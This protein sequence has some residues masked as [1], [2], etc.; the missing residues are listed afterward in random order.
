MSIGSAVFLLITSPLVCVAEHT[1]LP[2]D[3]QNKGFSFG[4]GI[5]KRGE[6][7]RFIAIAKFC[8]IKGCSGKHYAKG[9]CRYHYNR[10]E[11]HKQC[12]KRYDQEHKEQRK[13][14][15]KT[16]PEYNK[17][18]YKQNKERIAKRMKLYCQNNEERREYYK[19][20]SK[21][22]KGKA[23]KKA[24]YQNWR[25]LTKDLTA[26]IIQRVYEA[27][28]KRCGTLTCYLCFKPIV[29]GDDSLEH[30]TPLSRGGTND[31][32]NLGIAHRNCNSE[33]G[34]KTLSEWFNYIAKRLG[35]K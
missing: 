9:L 34:T 24:S 18:Y 15:R 17:Q 13:Q 25:A 10:S 7:G 26:E 30:S 32:G 31:F 28:I 12:L 21:T 4:E 11:C 5:M 1:V 23:C 14:W 16:H 6:K 19:R 27:N 29:F 35:V 33:K 3:T 8:S 22:P 2:I 20:W